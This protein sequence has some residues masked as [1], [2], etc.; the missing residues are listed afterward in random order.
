[1]LKLTEKLEVAIAVQMFEPLYVRGYDPVRWLHVDRPEVRYFLHILKPLIH[2]L[3]CFEQ[4]RAVHLVV[5][6]FQE[7]DGRRDE[8]V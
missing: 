1:M 6:L 3:V 2:R 4:L 8:E 5:E 7:Q